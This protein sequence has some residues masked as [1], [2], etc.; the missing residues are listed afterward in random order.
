QLRARLE[1][2]GVHITPTALSPLGLILDTRTNA[3]SL[4]SFRDGGFELQDE[5]SQLLG[6]LVDA[7]P[8]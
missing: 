8:T 1:Q 2:E 3:F 4:E 6:M 7:P 5:G